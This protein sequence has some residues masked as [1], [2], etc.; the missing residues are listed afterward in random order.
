[1]SNVLKFPER[2]HEQSQAPAETPKGPQVED[3]YTR[4]ANPIMDALCCADLTSREFRVLHFVIRTTYGW[5]TKACR[6]TGEFIAKKV[7]LDPSRCSKVLNEL[8]R[9]RVLIR[10][11]GSRSPVSLNKHVEEWEPREGA[12]RQAPTKQSDSAQDEPTPPKGADSAQDEPT[13]SAQDEPTKKDMKDIPPLPTVE[14]EG[15][16]PETGQKPEAEK[17]KPKA[18]PKGGTKPKA[19]KLDLSQL[20]DGVSLEAVEGF[21]EHRN[22][23]KKPLTQRALTLN[24]NEALRAAE[25]IPGMTADQALD[26]TVMA[27]WQGVKADWLARRQGATE[28]PAKG[29]NPAERL[30]AA[31][32]Q[33][34][35]EAVER[36]N[37]DAECKGDLFDNDG[38]HW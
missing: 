8:I 10:H 16:S 2:F 37:A 25:R 11:G 5:N 3:G 15:P 29:M 26:E 30:H 21:I 12:K 33:A 34:I 18:K 36:R 22:T 31:N 14:G 20:P 24:V 4:I 35:R 28:N 9:R 23:L 13:H 32:Q 38:G 17:P 6:M 1:M 19:A 27:G 7:K